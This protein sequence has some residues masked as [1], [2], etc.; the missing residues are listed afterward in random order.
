LKNLRDWLIPFILIQE[1]INGIGH[2]R[3]LEQGNRG[4]RGGIQGDCRGLGAPILLALSSG[5]DKIQ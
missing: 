4:N 5:N 1:K 2:L 3:G